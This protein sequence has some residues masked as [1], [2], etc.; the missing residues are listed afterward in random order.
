MMLDLIGLGLI[1]IA[2]ASIFYELIMQTRPRPVP[3]LVMGG[4]RQR[5][6][7]ERLAAERLFDR[8]DRRG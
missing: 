8:H 2:A 7:A 5:R 1:A 6:A 4:E 3:M